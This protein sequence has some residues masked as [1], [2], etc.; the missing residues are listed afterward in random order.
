M[1]IAFTKMHGLG[2]DFILVDNKL[3][4]PGTDFA[5]MSK[6]LCDRHFGIGGDGL[7]LVNPDNPSSDTDLTWRIFN[8]DGTEPQMCGN[9][10]RCF[11]RYVYDKGL[12]NK[13]EFSVSTLA[14]KIKPVIETGGMV[15]VDMGEPELD[16]VKVPVN[17][18]AKKVIDLPITVEGANFKINCISMGNPHCVI[19]IHDDI[20]I[21][22]FGPILEVHEIFPEKTN[23]EFVKV[24][25]R[26]HIKVNVWERGCGITLAC[27]TGACA[28]TV[29][30]VLNDL[31]ER[32]INVTLPGGDL[33][34]SYD[35]NSNHIFMTGPAE[36]AFD[37]EFF[38]E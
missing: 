37:G 4:P 15:T 36:Y 1:K 26:E 9:G 28:C 12:I 20:D 29:A 19:F 11:A 23:V 31:T 10:I 21:L 30:S 25:S 27:G 5:S 7:I 22:K 2:N 16:P 13:K 18:K 6:K 14:G 3:L 35:E 33:R 32:N 17:I 34:I 24:L 38:L 8:S